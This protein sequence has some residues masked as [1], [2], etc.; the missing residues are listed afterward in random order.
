MTFIEG[1]VIGAGAGIVVGA[2]L[3]NQYKAK[4]AAELAKAANTVGK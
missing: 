3:W 1:L 2:F 4:A